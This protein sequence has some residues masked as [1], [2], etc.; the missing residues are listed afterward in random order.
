MPQALGGW[1]LV[2]SEGGEGWGRVG[3]REFGAM[4]DLITFL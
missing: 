1:G 4:H 2:G 3:F